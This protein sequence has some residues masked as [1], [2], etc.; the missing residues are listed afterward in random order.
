[1]DEKFNAILSVILVPQIIDLIINKD[2][3][4]ENAAL[5]AF[6]QSKTYELLANEKT[7]L[8]HYSPLN[9]YTIWASEQ[10]TGSVILPED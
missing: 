7:K 9:I 1:M 2:S 4:D 3:L 5:N 10:K 8:W 6:Y